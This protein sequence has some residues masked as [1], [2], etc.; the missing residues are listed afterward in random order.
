[1]AQP[2][3]TYNSRYKRHRLT[4]PQYLLAQALAKNIKSGTAKG[5]WAEGIARVLQH[6]IAAD[7]RREADEGFK[8]RETDRSDTMRAA[9]EATQP[10]GG[11]PLGDG[12]MGPTRGNNGGLMA[13]ANVLMQNPDTSAMGW[14]MT[15]E[16]MKSRNAADRAKYALDEGR[17]Y[18]EGREDLAFDR[19]KELK[20]MPGSVSGRPSS[21]IQNFAER[22][23]LVKK[24]PPVNGKRSPQVA[25]FD[26]YVRA[27]KIMN[28]GDK[29]GVYNPENPS[30]PSA[31]VPIALK[32]GEQP[33]VKKQQAAA[34]AEGKAVG[35]EL[36]DAKARLSAADASMPRLEEAVT[37][38]K[39]LGEVATYT[40]AGRGADATRKEAGLEPS[41]GAVARSTYIAHVK[42]NVLP[43]LRQTFGAAFT[44][45]EGDSLLATLGDP[46]MHPR[47][48]E[49]VL[50]AFMSDKRAELEALRRQT[51][52]PSAT[53]PVPGGDGWSIKKKGS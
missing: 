22:Q 29:M 32:P 28:L 40:V 53:P 35:T 26:D 24:Y 7:A 44:A 13:G 43:L 4:D 48:K 5:G 49:A 15:M 16:H 45:A 10:S 9:F 31:E 21:P 14:D 47:E 17:R 41:K 18:K 11:E 33:S 25:R 50:N 39:A 38:L 37:N 23:R 19:K 36:G 20:G 51:G 6:K 30:V 12:V 42:N 27:S 34:T 2:R 1:M 46:N 3:S 52:S 8:S